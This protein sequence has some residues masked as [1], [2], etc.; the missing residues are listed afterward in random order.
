MAESYAVPHGRATAPFVAAERG[1]IDEVIEPA[2]TR[3][4]LIRALALLENKRDTNPPKKHGN[5]PLWGSLRWC[6]DP[7]LTAAHG[8]D[9]ASLQVF[10]KASQQFAY[11]LNTFVWKNVRQSDQTAMRNIFKENQPPEV[12]VD[13]D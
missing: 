2:Q 9:S 1:F 5:I 11:N 4:K 10:G 8:N 6:G 12:C 13:C 7:D 3:S